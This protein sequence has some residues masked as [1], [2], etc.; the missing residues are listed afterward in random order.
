MTIFRIPAS[1]QLVLHSVVCLKPEVR[2][3]MELLGE[4]TYV[5]VPSSMHR[6][7]APHYQSFYPEAKF[8][9]P[10]AALEKMNG[11]VNIHNTVE[12]VFHGASNLGIHF[13][14]VE[15]C[16]EKVNELAYILSLEN[17]EKSKA[18]LVTDLFFN[19]DP[20]KADFVTKMIGSA[21]GFGVTAIGQYMADNPL[22][23]QRWI[24]DTLINCPGKSLIDFIIVGHGEVI[25]GKQ[26]VVNALTKAATSLS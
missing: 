2:K 4:V 6:L 7:D 19:I 20:N 16:H 5:I 26:N 12:S 8:L 1:K 9:C 11:W 3:K 24:I 15:G 13:Q 23:I 21:N 17:P 14:C 10:E 25:E 18:L 22:K